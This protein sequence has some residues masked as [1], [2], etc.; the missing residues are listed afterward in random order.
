MVFVRRVVLG[1]L[2]VLGGVRAFGTRLSHEHRV[3]SGVLSQAL[4]QQDKIRGS[5][6]DQQEQERQRAVRGPEGASDPEARAKA[7]AKDRRRAEAIPRR[8]AE[9]DGVREEIRALRGRLAG[10]VREEI[11]DVGDAVRLRFPKLYGDFDLDA[12]ACADEPRGRPD[13]FAGI[14][15]STPR[16]APVLVGRREETD[17]A[18]RRCAQGADRFYQVRDGNGARVLLRASMVKGLSGSKTCA[19]FAADVAA[20][21]SDYRYAER[22]GYE[23]VEVM[24]ADARKVAKRGSR[25]GQMKDSKRLGTIHAR[26]S[27]V[28]RIAEDAQHK[29]A[30]PCWK[31]GRRRR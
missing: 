7:L 6:Q 25:V 5:L 10:G 21:F 13:G 3:L 2:C 8:L 1:G 9:V 4:A 26:P 15:L 14:V 17:E 29:T 28:D 22:D 23:Y 24:Y 20:W 30:V 31:L 11:T 12:H 19:Q 16:G 18:M 27:S